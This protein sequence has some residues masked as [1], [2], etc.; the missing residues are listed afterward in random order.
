MVRDIVIA[1]VFAVGINTDA[2]FTAFKIPNLLRRLTAEGALTQAF[3]PVFNSQRELEGEQQANNVRDDVASWL[4]LFL[5]VITLIGVLGAGVLVSLLAPGFSE[6]EGKQ[7]LATSLLQ[8]TFP[9]IFLIS[10]TAFGGAVLNSFGKFAAFA[11][12]PVLL[13][14]SMIGLCPMACTKTRTTSICTSLRG[15][16]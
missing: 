3:V 5:A 8:I 10:M 16:S 2:F 14:L 15:L 4:A 13:N 6:I 1:S 7:E 9:Y 12:A 11:F